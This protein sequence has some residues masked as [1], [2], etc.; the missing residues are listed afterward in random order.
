MN[1][2]F[3]ATPIVYPL[4]QVPEEKFGIPMRRITS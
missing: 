4:S 2:L 3:Y 1:V